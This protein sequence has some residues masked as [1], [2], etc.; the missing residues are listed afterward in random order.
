MYGDTL[1]MLIQD[2]N[3]GG[4]CMKR[5]LSL[6][7]LSSVFVASMDAQ[8][9]TEDFN[10]NSRD[11]TNWQAPVRETNNGNLLEQN[12]R[13]EFTETGS[14][15]QWIV[16]ELNNSPGYDDPWQAQMLISV[17]EGGFASGQ[18]AS[19]G[20]EVGATSPGSRAVEIGF[21]AGVDPLL[22]VGEALFS[23]GA[24]SSMG[25]DEELLALTSG[26]V[27]DVIGVRMTYDPYTRIIRTYY[28]LD[29]DQADGEWTYLQG[30]TI[31]NTTVT[32]TTNLNWGMTG[33]DNFFIRITAGSEGGAVIASG[34]AWVDDFEFNLGSSVQGSAL[35]FLD[36]F[37]DD[38]IDPNWRVPDIV[39]GTPV[40][41][42]MNQRTELISSDPVGAQELKRLISPQF[43][44]QFNQAFEVQV[45]AHCLP[46]G[47]D[48]N[49]EIALTELL[50]A[51]QSGDQD[52]LVS[53]GVG[54]LGSGVQ[55]FRFSDNSAF[56][57]GGPPEIL[58]SGI[59]LPDV[60]GIRMVWNPDSKIMNCYF[61]NDGDRSV[62]TWVLFSSYGLA[63]NSQGG[64]IPTEWNMGPA[65]RFDIGISA[66]AENAAVIS[67]E[68]YFDNFSFVSELLLAGFELWAA[69]IPDVGMRGT[70]DDASGN[71]I[72][73]L[74][75]YM[76][77][78]DPLAADTDVK[79]SIDMNGNVPELTHGFNTT[80]ADY[81]IDYMEKLALTDSWLAG[82]VPDSIDTFQA[83]GKT[84]RRV[85]LPAAVGNEFLQLQV[86]PAP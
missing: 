60:V 5:V 72:P 25:D 11:V 45:E 46:L 30:Y 68:V 54:D 29:E 86:V 6:I 41:A 76:Y 39:D 85:T 49:G 59:T 75:Q 10:D 35:A 84:F 14:T 4:H 73:N 16:Q 48:A 52:I 22:P 1:P 74:L 56:A 31:D 58:N 55:Q 17:A 32:G 15:D 81:V 51:N 37:D 36:D 65:D 7:T 12:Q 8:T 26:D 80:A 70:T 61:D 23:A 34:S 3:Y 82:F 40:F 13:L 77:G 20:I 38:S 18:L 28:D 33:S 43:S 47:V 57:P 42:E 66:L 21:A 69:D 44:P 63:G 9:I 2:Y 64:A 67:G 79:L 71:G 62:E 83:N 50:V 19:M 78:L 24:D 53:I 27:P